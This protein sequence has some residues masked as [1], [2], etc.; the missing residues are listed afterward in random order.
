MSTPITPN[1]VTNEKLIQGLLEAHGDV[2]IDRAFEF[3]TGT[4]I[5]QYEARLAA[6]SFKSKLWNT[7]FA[8]FLILAVVAVCF[9]ATGINQFWAVVAALFVG[10]VGAYTRY[11]LPGIPMQGK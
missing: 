6:W 2:T 10:L 9:P 1:A 3:F 8:G 5:L 7:I 11:T 4:Q